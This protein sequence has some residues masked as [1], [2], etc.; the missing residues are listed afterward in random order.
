MRHRRKKGASVDLRGRLWVINFIRAVPFIAREDG[1]VEVSEPGEGPQQPQPQPAVGVQQQLP[2]PQSYAHQPAPGG[3]GDAAAGA[4]D[5][6]QQPA[7]SHLSRGL[8]LLNNAEAA[9]DGDGRAT[10]EQLLLAATRAD[11]ADPTGVRR[12]RNRRVLQDGRQGCWLTCV[13][14]THIHVMFTL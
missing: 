5:G 7:G 4:A 8:S 1:V 13:P 2:P 14:H 6:E 12:L 3:N 10:M 11:P 9:G